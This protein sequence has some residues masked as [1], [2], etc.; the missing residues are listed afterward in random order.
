MVHRALRG[1]SGAPKSCRATSAQKAPWTHGRMSAVR[2]SRQSSRGTQQ[3]SRRRCL[4]SMGEE[5]SVQGL[6]RAKEAETR[7]GRGGGGG[8]GGVFEVAVAGAPVVPAAD[9]VVAFLSATKTLAEASGTASAIIVGKTSTDWCPERRG[10]G[11]SASAWAAIP[12]GRNEFLMRP[13]QLFSTKVESAKE[14]Q[15]PPRRCCI[16]SST[17]SS[18]KRREKKKETQHHRKNA[19]PLSASLLREPPCRRRLW[20]PSRA[21]AATRLPERCYRGGSGQQREERGRCC[22][23]DGFF[24]VAA[25]SPLS[26]SFVSFFSS[27]AAPPSL[28]CRQGIQRRRR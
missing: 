18:E 9:D 7:V 1:L 16:F 8:G 2:R 24:D 28:A 19:S 17:R 4:A 27:L 26:L 25:P 21:A 6:F 11:Q 5:R 13:S 22:S 12:V 14:E 3:R 15:T 23:F 20:D 10:G